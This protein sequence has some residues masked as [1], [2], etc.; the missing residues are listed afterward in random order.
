M[1]DIILLDSFILFVSF[2][3]CDSDTYYI[4]LVYKAGYG[5]IYLLYKAGVSMIYLLYKDGDGVNYLVFIY[6]IFKRYNIS[7]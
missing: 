4:R 5:M 6:Y 7:I 2:S 3:L 1:Y